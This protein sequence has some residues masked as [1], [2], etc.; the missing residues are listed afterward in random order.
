MGVGISERDG[1][2]ILRVYVSDADTPIVLALNELDD[3]RFMSY[4]FEIIVIGDISTL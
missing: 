3:N 4:P 2:S 1:V